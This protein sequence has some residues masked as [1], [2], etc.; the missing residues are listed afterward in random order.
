MVD[1]K[2]QI[3]EEMKDMKA[4]NNAFTFELDRN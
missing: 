2:L 1:M 4:A 3:N